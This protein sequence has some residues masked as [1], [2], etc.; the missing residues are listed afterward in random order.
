MQAGLAIDNHGRLY[1]ACLSGVLCCMNADG[2]VNWTYD[3][4]SP[5]TS[6]PTLLPDGTV[7]VG[8]E[9]GVLHAV[10]S[11]GIRQWTY[12]T[13]DGI[14]GSATIGAN[15][16]IVFGSADG[17]VYAL[18]RQGHL[19]W[20]RPFTSEGLLPPAI[21]ASV[22]MSK[23]G[24]IYAGMVRNP[25]LYA[26]NPVDG[27]VKWT[28]RFPGGSGLVVSPVVGPGGVIYQTLEHDDHLYAVDPKNGSILWATPL[29]DPHQGWYRMDPNASRPA[30][31]IAGGWSEPVLGPDGTIYVSL[32]D[33]YLRAVSSSGLLKWG[34]R[35][36]DVGTFTLTVSREGRIYAAC[37]NGVLYVV[38]A[39]GT[40][41]AQAAVDHAISYPVIG[42]GR[43]VLVGDPT[44]HGLSKDA[45]N[46]VLILGTRWAP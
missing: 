24:S 42:P 2:K 44:D 34:V 3:A 25:D 1:I 17:T 28:C 45:S 20:K 15:G 22:A 33:P 8:S 14:Y 41:V 4:N 39:D 35:L 30:T 23:D 36:G 13:G 10:S 7:V 12:Q 43:T 9:S 18:D 16:L 11:T 31:N 21:F 26:L 5:L 27:T 46:R 37:A 32:G 6:T 29:A 38:N 19:V 40:I